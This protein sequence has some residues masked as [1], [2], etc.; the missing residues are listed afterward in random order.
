MLNRIF[1]T[2]FFSFICSINEKRL[3]WRKRNLGGLLLVLPWTSPE[4]LSCC[5]LLSSW[6]LFLVFSF[7]S[8]ASR[9]E[10]DCIW[11][12]CW[13]PNIIIE[14]FPSCT[15]PLSFL[16]FADFFFVVGF[17]YIFLFFSLVFIVRLFLD[18]G[19]LQWVNLVKSFLSVHY[20][21]LLFFIFVVFFCLFSGATWRTT[22]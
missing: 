3:F 9:M 6:M 13:L 8:G 20:S 17:R 18:R 7:F 4:L 2:I 11:V 10:V 1:E 15:W 21:E 12:T 5:F 14:G 22:V 19:Y 16:V